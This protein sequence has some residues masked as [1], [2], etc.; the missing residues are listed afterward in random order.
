M[1]N[2]PG[3]HGSE[4]GHGQGLGEN[5][6]R[7][8]PSCPGSRHHRKSLSPR[9]KG[10]GASQTLRRR[11]SGRVWNPPVTNSHRRGQREGKG[12]RSIPCSCIPP[13]S[14][15]P[16]LLPS[17]IPAPVPDHLS[18]DP[19]SHS[20]S[21]PTSHPIQSQFPP[22]STDY[23]LQFFNKGSLFFPPSSIP[24]QP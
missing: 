10:R 18:S 9:E 21:Q 7:L 11:N 6:A 20:S 13:A 19:S 14:Q 8:V 15:L 2:P 4:I 17:H 3:K 12:H 1:A 22:D 23:F 16:S 5:R 24:V